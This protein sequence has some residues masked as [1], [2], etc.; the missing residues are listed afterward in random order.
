MSLRVLVIGGGIFGCSIARVLSLDGFVV[1]LV[2]KEDQILTSTTA[3]NIFRVHKGLHYPR[4]DET[5]IQSRDSYAQFM[6][7]FA[8]CVD[9]SFPN[10]YA[11]AKEGSRTTTDSFSNFIKRTYLQTHRVNLDELLSYGV[12]TENL[13]SA[14]SCI[15]GVYNIARLRAKFL[16]HFSR[17]GVS[18][19]TN[20]EILSL[21][22]GKRWSVSSLERDLGDFDFVVRATNKSDKILIDGVY[23]SELKEFQTTLVLECE[24]KEIPKFGLTVMDGD[25]LTLMPASFGSTF[26]L[27]APNPSVLRRIR[28]Y[29]KPDSFERHIEVEEI[30]ESS[31]EILRRFRYYFNGKFEINV[32]KEILGLRVIPTSSFHDDRRT[33]QIRVLSEGVLDIVSGKVDHAIG[34]ANDVL[35]LLKS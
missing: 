15:E 23:E 4:S 7:L 3:R 33:S 16:E 6:A 27:Y 28:A 29:R 13:E 11:I 26:F 8:D 24:S 2:E 19:S 32:S 17:Y 25:F 31:Q 34:V 14:W 35:A 18:L 22:K 5:A 9:V 20:T 12:R 30:R 1:D 10:F 21:I